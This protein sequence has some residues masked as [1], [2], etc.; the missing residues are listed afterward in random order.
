MAGQRAFINSSRD[1]FLVKTNHQGYVLW[2]SNFGTADD[3]RCHTLTLLSDGGFLMT[4][5]RL[6]TDWQ[7]RHL[8]LVKADEDGNL[9]WEKSYEYSEEVLS[10]YFAAMELPNGE[11]AFVYRLTAL[12]SPTLMRTDAQGDSLFTTP[13][14]SASLYYDAQVASDGNILL[15]GYAQDGSFAIAQKIDADGNDIF[16]TSIEE[17][18]AVYGRGIGI[19]ET[20]DG[21]ALVLSNVRFTFRDTIVLSKLDA[22]GNVEWNQIFSPSENSNGNEI[23]RARML[24]TTD[25]NFLMAI[26][27]FNE[28]DLPDGNLLYLVKVDEQGNE[29]WSKSL[30][31]ELNNEVI[32]GASATTAGGILLTGSGGNLATNSAD[33]LLVKTLEDGTVATFQLD[34][35][36]ELGLSPNPSTGPLTIKFQSEYLG[37][38]SISIFDVSGQLVRH[39]EEQKSNL[40][41][42]RSYQLHD[43]P[44][45]SYF[46]RLSANGRSIARTWL[47]S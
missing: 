16:S 18:T 34:F 44:S 25:G 29:I 17:N 27:S 6:S 42:E 30:E 24:K 45:G 13:L 43:L 41:M 11:L 14:G 39:F 47:K 32:Y 33:M 7:T 23:Y 8:V 10:D 15:T 26:L 36:G 31:N 1:F 9:V 22:S 19:E 37:D 4:G 2:H 40:L 5:L 28:D 20:A 46:V 21:G 3:E 38:V 35:L 12:D